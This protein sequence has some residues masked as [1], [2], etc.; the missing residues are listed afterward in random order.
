M[1]FALIGEID[2]AWE[3]FALLN[4]VHHGGTLEQIATYKVEP[5]VVAADVY[6]AAPHTGRG[7]WTGTRAPPAGCIGCSSKRCWA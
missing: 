6:G 4:P 7:G 3:L 1:A 5:Y 2:R